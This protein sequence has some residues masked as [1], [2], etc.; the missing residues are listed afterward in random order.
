MFDEVY[1]GKIGPQFTGA[2]Q[3]YVDGTNGNDGN[4]G[5]DWAHAFATIQA[6]ITYQIANS[7]GLGD[8]IWIAP[9]S[10]AE[11]LTGDLTRV[12]LIGVRGQYPWHIA[13][14][15][16]VDGPAY[17]GTIFEA[18]IKNLMILSPSTAVTEPA[19]LLTNARYS[20]IEDCHFVGRD[21]TC[22][23]GIQ[24]GPVADDATE[25]HLDFCI[26]RRNRFDTFYGNNS[27]FAAG[28]KVGA[29]AG[30]GG[31]AK[32]IVGTT[33]EDNDIYAR[34]YG[35][36]VLS[37]PPNSDYCIIRRNLID[38]MNAQNG[39]AVAGIEFTG[40][41]FPTIADNR[42]NAADAIIYPMANQ[43]RVFN[44]CV[45]N[46]GVGPVMEMPVRT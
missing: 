15:R 38:S 22:E 6:A 42:I 29:V 40:G 37:G 35:I 24:I 34:N 27:E 8:I 28:I 45:T 11:D 16:P 21:A 3:L 12:A 30:V 26:I 9:G 44:N 39:C 4:N 10:Y 19:M 5:F 13:S 31:G 33:I 18:L 32:Q 20:V 23:E 17:F 46:G 1:R 41:V 7:S 14:I 36:Y 43:E 25:A 2:L